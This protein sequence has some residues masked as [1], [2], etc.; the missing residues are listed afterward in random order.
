MKNTT[1]KRQGRF[2]RYEYGEDLFGYLFLDVVSGKRD[3]ARRVR[4][5]LFSDVRHLIYTLD[6][7]IDRRENLNYI[8]LAASAL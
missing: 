5:H 6:V 3:Q 8:P 7:E 2:V 1:G 4:T